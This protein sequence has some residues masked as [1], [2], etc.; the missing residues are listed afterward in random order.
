MAQ[1]PLNIDLDVVEFDNTLRQYIEHSKKDLDEIVFNKGFQLAGG[2]GKA[3]PGALQLTHHA[4]ANQIRQELSQSVAQEITLSRKGKLRRGK[5]VTTH[6]DD[7][8]NS[9]AA[10][11][12]NAKRLKEGQPPIWGTALEEEARKL[13]ALRVRAVNFLRSGWIPAIRKL[14]GL[15]RRSGGIDGVKQF[16]QPKGFALVK[17]GYFSPSV[18]IVNTALKTK[19]GT[20]RLQGYAEAGLSEALRRLT[21]DMRQYIERKLQKT[22]DKYSAR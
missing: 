18:E 13:V 3:N 20:G 14:A 17:Q 4:D 6:T 9:F 7:G 22:A 21:A 15:V 2:F 16:G 1:Q 8:R 5:I 10:R 12:V 19:G 11:I